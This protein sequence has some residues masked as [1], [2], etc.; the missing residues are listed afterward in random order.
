MAECFG[1]DLACLVE[2]DVTKDLG[3]SMTQYASSAIRIRRHKRLR[4]GLCQ[5]FSCIDGEL[6]HR[7]NLIE[8][9]TQCVCR[10]AAQYVVGGS[11]GYILICVK[12]A[13]VLMAS[14]VMCGDRLQKGIAKGGPSRWQG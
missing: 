7:N 9:E 1:A 2:C 13:V 6:G 4:V 14:W 12:R 3:E 10:C 11:G 8:S 5:T